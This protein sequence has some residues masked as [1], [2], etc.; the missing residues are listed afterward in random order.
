MLS[1]F[2]LGVALLVSALLIL[3]WA[4]T[5]DPRTLVRVLKWVLIGLVVLLA[6]VFVLTG[7]A[8]WAL[9]GLPVLF[10]VLLRLI[11]AWR[12]VRNFSRMA[13]AATGGSTGRTSS[14]RTRVL[15]PT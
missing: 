1:W 3:R 4:S 11:T 9:A 7:R 14:I 2:I 6:L 5:A 15:T 10:P 13:N 12:A 8:A